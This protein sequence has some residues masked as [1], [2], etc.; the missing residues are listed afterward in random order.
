MVKTMDREI[1]F[2]G[3]SMGGRWIYGLLTKKKIRNS[4]RISFA[5]ATE[6]Y[7]LAN[8]IPISENTIGQFTGFKDIDGKEIFEGDIIKNIESDIIYQVKLCNGCWSAECQDYYASPLYL[9]FGNAPFK[10]IG[11]I[12]DTPE[13]GK[14]LR[15]C[16]VDD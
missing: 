1:E 3:K 14:T 7:S 15:G 4:G 6:D 11:N 10:V 16:E 9:L 5:I 12:H 13:L 8:T 2:R